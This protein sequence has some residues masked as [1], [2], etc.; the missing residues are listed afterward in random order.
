MFGQ[1]FRYRGVRFSSFNR[2]EKYCLTALSILTFLLRV[3]LALRPTAMLTALPYGDDAYYLFSI[4]RHLSS[5]HG[6]SVDG[7]HLT[8]GFQPL[9]LLFYTPIFWLFGSNAWLAVRWTFVMNA[10]IS[11]LTIWTGAFTVRALE[12][13]TQRS[14]VSAPVIFAA[15]S[16]LGYEFFA[17]MTNGLET[18]L[19]TLL[20]LISIYYYNKIAFEE[21][22]ENAP[23]SEY[24]ALGVVLGLTV[25]ARI[26]A[27]ILVAIIVLSL[28][29]RRKIVPAIITGSVTFLIT[30]PWWL[31]NVIYFG[32]V[33]PSSG[34]AEN[35]WPV[36]PGISLQ[37]AV[38]SLSEII[39]LIFYLPG[40]FGPVIRTLWI[41]A[42]LSA[43][44]YAFTRTRLKNV[45]RTMRFNVL[46]PFI[47]FSLI[48]LV[49]YTFFFGAP[50]FISRYMQPMRI[51]WAIIVSFAASWLWDQRGKFARVL[52]TLGVVL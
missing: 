50:H 30:L 49:Y 1:N 12:R 5:G 33:M 29:L 2:G 38:K 16:G 37:S 10:A 42:L 32:N 45:L 3:P 19:L 17:Q 22:N 34:Q 35:S 27:A 11:A 47:L 23:R 26:D 18:G 46:L 51:L 28:F 8:N 14:T 9:I 7:I 21:K 6:I 20:L 52:L 40:S 4:A 13:Q 15:L 41:L 25:L 24:I 43:I 31:Y 39:T 48:L 36:P 44:V